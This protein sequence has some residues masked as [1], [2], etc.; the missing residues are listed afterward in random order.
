MV[1]T[2]K[3]YQRLVIENLK[4]WKKIFQVVNLTRRLPFCY[5]I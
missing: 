2:K 1:Q 5:D 3:N 4:V